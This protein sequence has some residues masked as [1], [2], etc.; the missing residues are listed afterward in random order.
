MK[1]PRLLEIRPISIP[2]K[3]VPENALLEA[4]VD[5]IVRL[6]GH[7]NVNGEQAEK[8]EA[9]I[10]EA[11]RMAEVTRKRLAPY[12]ALDQDTLSREDL[13]EGLEKLLAEN[14]VDNRIIGSSPAR[15]GLQ[16][17]I[18]LILGLLLITTGFAMIIMPAPPS[19]EIATVFYFNINDG[20]TIMDL[21]SLMII[22]GG[23]L[24]IVLN[25]SKK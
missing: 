8:F 16:T 17:V 15:K 25:F 3:K 12:E 13:L 11:F 7:A 9:R 2:S 5:E 19:F 21:V 6:I 4:K 10:S 20:V 1:I 24:L 14:P 22:F 23:V 18:M